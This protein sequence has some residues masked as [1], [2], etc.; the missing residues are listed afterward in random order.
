MELI[1]AKRM[2]I[3]SGFKDFNILYD[4][5]GIQDQCPYLCRQALYQ[6]K[7]KLDSK[8]SFCGFGYLDRS[9]I[10]KAGKCPIP[11]A[12]DQNESDYTM[13]LW[14]QQVM[15]KESVYARPNIT[16]HMMIKGYIPTIAEFV[17]FGFLS[18][19]RTLTALASN[20]RAIKLFY[21]RGRGIR[22]QFRNESVFLGMVRNLASR[23]T[24][25][26]VIRLMESS[27][28]PQIGR[29]HV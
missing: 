17:K 19:T 7:F 11:N 5:L 22:R 29:A 26:E 2:K 27:Y 20:P 9:A 24:K 12:E 21:P 25:G 4:F 1:E 6:W 15:M 8:P 3:D 18:T 23:L 13:T 28:N 16:M 14:K 10:Q